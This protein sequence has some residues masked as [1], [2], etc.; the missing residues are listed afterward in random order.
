VFIVYSKKNL[1]KSIWL[2]HLFPK[3]SEDQTKSKIGDLFD[4][5]TGFKKYLIMY[6]E[7]Y[8]STDL[9]RWIDLLK[10]HDMIKAK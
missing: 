9:N 1:L 7:H 3:L 8:E 5:V 6:L 2:S 10:C 4:S